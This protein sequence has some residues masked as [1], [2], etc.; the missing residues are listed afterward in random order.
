M[1]KTLE[2]NAILEKNNKSYKSPPKKV[3]RTV[4]A[5]YNFDNNVVTPRNRV[6]ETRKLKKL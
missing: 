2:I 3:Y 1:D 5:P 4:E 6:R